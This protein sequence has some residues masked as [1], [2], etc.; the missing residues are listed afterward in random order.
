MLLL[1]LILSAPAAE[2][3][4]VLS[5]LDDQWRSETSH[6]VM[7]LAVKTRRFERSIVMEV[8]SQGTERSRMTIVEP[9]KDK[10]ITTLLADGESYSILPSVGKVVR[11]PAM[12]LGSRWMG[13]HLTQDDLLKASRFEE[14]Y[15]CALVG[16][17]GLRC[18]PKPE[19]PVPWD[20]VEA[21][22]RAEDLAPLAIRY[23]EGDDLSRTITLSDHREL[24]GRPMAMSMVVQPTDE[25]DERTTITWRS[26]EVDV[27]L[28]QALF[29]PPKEG[30][31]RPG[32]TP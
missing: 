15:D 26:L 1:S 7:E 19:A 4:E 14:E 31:V 5:A 13:S 10:G 32:E 27:E 16:G 28:D 23:F 9:D 6:G 18:T 21:D 25:P 22:F 12:M 11:L 30:G 17:T 24:G 3:S 2:L 8:W 29:I 20:R